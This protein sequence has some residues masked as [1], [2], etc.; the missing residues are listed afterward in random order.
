MNGSKYVET[1]IIK[2]IYLEKE[3]IYIKSFLHV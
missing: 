3:F 2:P 1:L